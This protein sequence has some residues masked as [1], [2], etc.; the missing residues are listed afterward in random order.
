MRR[1][2]MRKYIT[3]LF[4]GVFLMAGLA[5]SANELIKWDANMFRVM[6]G[7][8]N[9]ANKY[10]SMI[11]VDPTSL[12]VVVH[13]DG[14]GTVVSAPN[15]YAT[16]TVANV[17]VSATSVTLLASNSSRKDFSITNDSPCVLYVKF[18]SAATTTTSY[19]Y[20]LIQGASLTPNPTGL[21][22]GII[23]GIWASSCGGNGALATEG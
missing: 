8:T 13:S 4:L 12:G 7:V 10:I 20:Q 23:T 17:A 14:T 19:S 15:T 2:D 6:A 22:T 11:R 16:A 9:D 5:W 1:I 18:G 21:Y 3:G